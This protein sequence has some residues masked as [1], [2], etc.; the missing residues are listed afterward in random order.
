MSINKNLLLQMKISTL[1]WAPTTTAD[2][3]II[4]RVVTQF[5]WPFWPEPEKADKTFLPL[6]S[7]CHLLQ[8][9]TLF[10][11]WAAAVCCISD[12]C[13]ESAVVHWSLVRGRYW[14]W[15][16]TFIFVHLVFTFSMVTTNWP[17]AGMINCVEVK[18]RFQ[19]SA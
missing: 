15:G 19:F 16:W 4:L 14:G 18:W 11:D 3:L 1:F 9:K 12:L 10:S 5:F 13:V 6:I 7:P 8:L 2:I 17:D